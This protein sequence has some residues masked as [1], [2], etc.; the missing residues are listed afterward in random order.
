MAMEVTQT[1][2]F[3]IRSN[4]FYHQHQRTVEDEHTKCFKEEKPQA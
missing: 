2:C 3:N 4:K 1:N